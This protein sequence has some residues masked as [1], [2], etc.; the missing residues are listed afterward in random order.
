MTVQQLKNE[1]IDRLSPAVGNREATAMCRV[2]L[3]DAASIDR[4]NA[5]LNPARELE[6]ETVARVGRIVSEVAGGRPLQYVLGFTYFHGLKLKVD[7]SVLIPRP[8]TS[9]LVDIILDRYKDTPDLKVVDFCTGSGAIAIALS[10][11]LPFA[12]IVA[13]DISDAALRTAASNISNLRIRNVTLKK[14][15]VL[16]EDFDCSDGE[17][18][19][20]VSNPPY[21]DESEKIGIDRR[22]TDYEPKLALFVP[23]DNPLLFYRAIV[24]IASKKLKKGGAIFFEIN[25][26]HASGIETLLEENGFK[27]VE[28]LRDFNN[29]LRFAAAIHA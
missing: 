15:D 9:Q 3:E 27:E 23:D 10:R 2:I 16:A 8:E 12:E 14:D 1:I 4:I 5:T 29:S 25:P 18:D 28:L 13:T 24:N 21:V 26:R 19:I 17:L 6:E 22:V 11:N 20:I 7:E